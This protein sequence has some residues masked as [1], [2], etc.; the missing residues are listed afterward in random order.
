MIKLREE[1]YMK[2]GKSSVLF[3]YVPGKTLDYSNIYAINQVSKIDGISPRNNVASEYVGRKVLRRVS[4]WQGRESSKGVF[5]FPNIPSNFQLVQP[6]EVKTEVFP[7]LFYCQ[8]CGRVEYF[9]DSSDINKYNNQ[10]KCKKDTCESNLK[11]Y[12]FVAIHGCGNIESLKPPKKCGSC[13]SY[14]KWHLDTSSQKFAN[15]K[16]R[17]ECGKTK[18]ISQYCNSCNLSEKF[19]TPAVHR[20]S[21]VYSAHH[22][23]FINI[24]GEDV[25]QTS[26]SDVKKFLASYVGISDGED[27]DLDKEE[28]NERIDEL[29]NKISLFEE[30][31]DEATVEQEEEQYRKKK[32]EAEEE[33]KQLNGVN[34]S[35][36]EKVESFLPFTRY[37]E[38][39]EDKQDALEDAFEQTK[40][41]QKLQPKSMKEVICENADDKASEK[42]RERKADRIDSLLQEKGIESTEFIDDFPVSTVVFGYSRNGREAD[43]ATLN[44]FN[45]GEATTPNGEGT[46]LFFDTVRTEA[47]RFSLDPQK[48]LKWISENST[49]DFEEAKRLRECIIE[50]D[51]PADRKVPIPDEWDHKEVQDWVGSDIELEETEKISNWTEEHIRAWLINNSGKIPPYDTINL[52]ENPEQAITYFVYHLVH[53]YSHVVLKQATTISG[54]E[55]TSLSEYLMPWSLS[56]IVYSN[57]RKQFNIGGIYT[58]IESG[59]EDLFS[60]ISQESKNCVYDPVCSR[61][62]SSCFSCMHLSEVSCVHLNRNIG[63]D[64]LF[65][66]KSS[67]ERQTVGYWRM[68]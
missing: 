11:Q 20:G 32:K 3:D 30:L 42:L 34:K 50:S 63:R 33:L 28:N 37:E 44:A 17:C 19:M 39:S 46:P 12:Q 14:D 1:D 47:V 41:D 52:E 21:N 62:G 36:G 5:G 10:L 6:L 43:E 57:N 68:D 54:F 22:F 40:I 24:A 65:G 18:D 56:F 53:S 13:G 31:L 55:R 45:E 8:E 64:F 29:E 25:N 38:I 49:K 27:I 7:R 51:L 35:I 15:F 23:S 26:S 16:W 48:C 58:L 59:L 60:G 67:S 66:A 61:R 4:Q 2:R 9:N